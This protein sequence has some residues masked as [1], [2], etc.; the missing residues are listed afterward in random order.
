VQKANI[1]LYHAGFYIACKIILGRNIYIS[2]TLKNVIY[3]ID[4][5][6]FCKLGG[7]VQYLVEFYDNIERV[8][9]YFDKNIWRQKW[10]WTPASFWYQRNQPYANVVLD[11][12]L[13]AGPGKYRVAQ[14]DS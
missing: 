3:T 1:R 7:I 5:L 11:G 8:N 13:I 9:I 6:E 12:K 4:F 10:Y 2:W 14:T